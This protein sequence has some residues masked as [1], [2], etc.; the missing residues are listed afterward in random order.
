MPQSGAARGTDKHRAHRG[1]TVTLGGG[2]LEGHLQLPDHSWHQT[3]EEEAL[4][5]PNLLSCC[6][7]TAS[8]MKKDKK[9]Q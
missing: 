6:V 4:Y 3:G 7:I 2:R 1:P 9:S 8:V 5:F